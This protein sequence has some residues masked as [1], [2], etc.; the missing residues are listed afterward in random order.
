MFYEDCSCIRSNHIWLDRLNQGSTL[1]QILKIINTE[2][3]QSINT[4]DTQKQS[5]MLCFLDIECNG[6][7]I[8]QIAYEIHTPDLQIVKKRNFIVDG[9]SNL[10]KKYEKRNFAEFVT[11]SCDIVDQILGELP[12]CVK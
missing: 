6:N 8:N 10:P 4:T 3:T 1:P 12:D 2:N 7:D 9:T 11:R 5:E